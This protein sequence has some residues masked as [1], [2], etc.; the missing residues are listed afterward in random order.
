MGID[1][2]KRAE[3]VG[4]VLSKRNITQV[5]TVRVGVA[6]DVSGSTRSM[7][8]D[9]IIQETVDRLLAVALKFDDNGELDVWTF[10]N[11][12]SAVGTASGNDYNTYVQN[13]IL[14][15]NKLSLWGGTSYAPAL[16]A[17]REFYFPDQKAVAPKTE[18]VGFLSK[19]FGKKDDP[20]VESTSPA[21]VDV[22]V[23][24][25]FVTDGSNDDRA[26]AE[27][28]LKEA[29]GS[30]VYWQMIG[31]GP[32]SYFTF[33]EKMADDLPNVGF[34]NL[35]SLDMTD[36]ELYSELVSEEFSTW[37]KQV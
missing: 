20:V 19:L 15:N 2:Q 6:L 24:V 31:V 25:L 27:R 36:E 22:P 17:I 10:D 11:V 12:A 32:A 14:N 26:A 4:I 34:V 1:L 30:N 13:N 35:N 29:Q 8:R 3:T 28:V 23:M 7:F 37:I 9:G 18:K 33:I 21:S 5:P 16:S